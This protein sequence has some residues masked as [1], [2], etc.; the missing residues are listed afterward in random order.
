MSMLNINMKKTMSI[1]IAILLTLSILGATMPV[2]L[3]ANAEATGTITAS[4]LTIYGN[5]VVQITVSDADLLATNTPM[6]SVTIN[7]ELVIDNNATSQG[8]NLPMYQSV[9]GSWVGF[10][11][12]KGSTV[13]STVPVSAPTQDATNSSG[14]INYP[15]GGNWAAEVTGEPFFTS[16]AILT[17]AAINDLIAFVHGSTVGTDPGSSFIVT[18]ND[19]NPSTSTSVTITVAP[20]L[21]TVTL[22]R[23]VYPPSGLIFASINDMDRNLDPT[24]AD[25]ISRDANLAVNTYN[26][27]IIPAARSPASFGT[28]TETGPNTGVF[29]AV[30]TLASTATIGDVISVAYSDAA[31]SA[32]NRIGSASIGTNTGGIAL[33]QSTYVV[34]DVAT[35]TV[36]DPDLN[37]NAYT[38]E[39]ITSGNGSGMTAGEA[40]VYV[41]GTVIYL[42]MTETGVNTGKFTD[43]FG[44]TTGTAAAGWSLNVSAYSLITAAYT[45]GAGG[46]GSSF[47]LTSTA[48]F[49]TNTGSITLDADTYTS[50]STATVTMTDP[51]LD[52]TLSLPDRITTSDTLVGVYSDSN[53]TLNRPLMVE[54]GASTGKFEG[55]FTFTSSGS[56]GGGNIP[57]IEVA[58]GDIVYAIYSDA[59]SSAGTS[60]TA[61]DTATYSTATNT[62]TIGLS[63]GAYAAGGIT[64]SASGQYIVVTVSDPDLNNKGTETQ[65]LVGS[66]T[67]ASPAGSRT[68]L[69]IYSGNDQVGVDMPITIMESGPATGIFSGSIALNATGMSTFVTPGMVA[70]VTYKDAS[71]AS[72]SAASAI[73]TAAVISNSATIVIDKTEPGIGDTVKVT[74][75]EPDANLSHNTIESVAADGSPATKASGYVYVYSTSDSNGISPALTETAIN[76]GVFTANIAFTDGSS[77]GNTLSAKRGD[78]I[79]VLYKDRLNAQGVTENV[80]TTTTIK[81]TTGTISLNKES[82]SPYG[83]IIVTINDPDVN[84][85]AATVDSIDTT[86]LSIK[87]TTMSAA[88]APT[89]ALSETAADTGIFLWAIT[90][91]GPDGSTW[92]TSH[93]D[94]I[95]VSYTEDTDGSGSREVVN[96]VYATASYNTG[97]IEFDATNYESTDT[98]TIT[99][100]DADQNTNP[101][102]LNSFSIRVVSDTDGGGVNL[103]VMET[104]LNTGIFTA[105]CSFTTTTSSTGG[106][107]RVTVG[108]TVTAKFTDASADPADIPGWLAGQATTKVITDTA[109]L[110]TIVVVEQPALP[111]TTGTPELQDANGNEIFLAP[112]D[113]PVQLTTELTND[114]T[115]NQPTLYIVQV[116]DGSGTVVY[117]GTASLTIPAGFSTT[118]SVSWTPS[119]SGLYTVEVYAWESWTSPAPLSLVQTSTITAA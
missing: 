67:T 93:G 119:T 51:D 89:S 44:F 107:L 70:Q 79:T 101:Y 115:I 52:L 43:A 117:I 104:G 29:L 108:D 68:Y 57:A 91:A 2:M 11:T 58:S 5:Q 3:T 74:L 23:D 54:T 95:A 78:T 97:T 99:I 24:A 118:F 40:I 12:L 55:K 105:T 65:I 85:N 114:A 22:D 116:K 59:S 113:T 73:A 92:M 8:N 61:A 49:L 100:N 83:Q 53:S 25:T 10:I 18:Y 98:A 20:T 110:G 66:G 16:S 27:T 35:A 47:N 109:T 4:N 21:G 31:P 36:T 103:S 14:S 32:G 15:G 87:T 42:N 39:T 102:V 17:T 64:A 88:T 75:T 106:I 26:A 71:A 46:T 84:S 86:R 45:D 81:A 94:G 60:Y 48:L 34:N 1:T 90:L 28:A 6:P 82:Y 9:G 33:D 63:K 62:G 72:G 50:T 76:D 7:K 77:S 37:L 19:A 111:I 69:Q 38:V 80:L 41:S 13:A 112:L 56:T 30:V 96:T